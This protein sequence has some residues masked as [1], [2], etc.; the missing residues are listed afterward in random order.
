[1]IEHFRQAEEA[2]DF[3]RRQWNPRPRIGIL[4][5]TGLGAAAKALDE[6]FSIDTKAIPHFPVSTVTGHRGRLAAGRL[7]GVE[8]VVLQGRV[9]LYEGYS[10]QQVAFPV[11]VLQALGV[12]TLVLTN[13]A[14]GIH[15]DFSSG[16]IMIITDHVNLT[17]E[18]P[19]VGPNDDRW[20]ERFPDMA[21]AWDTGLMKAAE[22]AAARIG[23]PVTSGTYAGLRGPSLETPA[24]I[25]FLRTIGCD[26]VGLSTVMEAIAGVHA[27]MRILGLSILTNVHDPDH[28]VP[29]R[30]EEIVALAQRIA[31]TLGRLIAEVIETAGV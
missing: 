27:G 17:G 9:H 31:P 4:A 20:G 24:E 23:T 7:A 5:G 26:A 28:P 18:N 10:A 11:R 16:D 12:T 21:R 8:A 2:A 3:L 19:L 22:K 6:E 29:A 25:R 30:L 1:M 13:A 15:P 14:G